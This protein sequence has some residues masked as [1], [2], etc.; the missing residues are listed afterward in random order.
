[1]GVVIHDGVQTSQ[2][3]Y[4]AGYSSCRPGHCD[5]EKTHSYV[6]TNDEGTA[7]AGLDFSVIVMF[8]EVA[9]NRANELST[10]DLV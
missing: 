2:T 10:R 4:L 8:A 3:S 7:Y 6:F 1:M 5:S 9:L